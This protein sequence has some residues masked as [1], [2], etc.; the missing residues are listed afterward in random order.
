MNKYNAKLE[1]TMS[2]H[3]MRLMFN[4]LEDE[5]KEFEV[6]FGKTHT[7]WWKMTLLTDKDNL[8]YFRKYLPTE[9]WF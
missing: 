9:P 3:V 4:K 8:E 1:I 2:G 7:G 6:T 5:Q